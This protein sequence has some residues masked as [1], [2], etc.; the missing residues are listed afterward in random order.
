MHN[1]APSA[2][3][4]RVCSRETRLCARIQVTE[5]SLAI[6]VRDWRDLYDVE[7]NAPAS[8]RRGSGELSMG[9]GF[10]GFAQDIHVNLVLVLGLRTHSR[11]FMEST[12]LDRDP[13]RNLS[14]KSWATWSQSPFTYHI[15]GIGR[16][17]LCLV[18]N[19]GQS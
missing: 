9:W 11:T 12:L 18:T 10:V 15:A 13:K 6:N 1:P 17:N 16:T 8:V 2:Y 3:L 4:G 14:L 19:T 7:T 5:V